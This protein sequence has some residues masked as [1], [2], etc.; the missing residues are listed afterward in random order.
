MKNLSIV[1][2][3][4]IFFVLCWGVM[5]PIITSFINT[6]SNTTLTAHLSRLIVFALPFI[7]IAALGV[8]LLLAKRD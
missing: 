2:V 1:V 7:L 6:G 4:F 5:T 3:L 8:V